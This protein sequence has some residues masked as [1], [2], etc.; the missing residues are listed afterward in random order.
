MSPSLVTEL[1]QARGETS[2]S[3]YVRSLVEAQLQK[4][5][6]ARQ[7]NLPGP[8][9]ERPDDAT[10]EQKQRTPENRLDAPVGNQADSSENYS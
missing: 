6:K 3:Q 7:S 9:T 4:K 8:S 1:D 10:L 5:V 2:R